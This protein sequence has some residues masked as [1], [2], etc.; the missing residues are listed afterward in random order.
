MPIPVI[1]SWK[2]ESLRLSVFLVEAI[3][4]NQQDWWKSI[5][6][7]ESETS[8]SK[9]QTGEYTEDGVFGDWRLTLAINTISHNRVDWVAYPATPDLISFSSIGSYVEESEKFFKL[10]NRWLLDNC[11]PTIRIA[12]GAVLLNEVSDRKAGYEIL[13]ACLPIIKFNP[14]SW[15]DFSFQVNN[16]NSS[17]VL[18]GMTLNILTKWNA[19]QMVRIPIEQTSSAHTDKNACRLEF[20]LSSEADNKAPIEA[21]NLSLLYTEF[22]TIADRY[23]SNGYP[24]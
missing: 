18:A 24:K 14:E 23:V 1:T 9:R 17:E 20:D 4:P 21:G 16:K 3:D 12:Y 10:F 8:T 13:S 11:P 6:G 22:R 15:T 7:L 5:T 2:L 19:I